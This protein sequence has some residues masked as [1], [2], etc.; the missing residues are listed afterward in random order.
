MKEIYISPDVEIIKFDSEDVI[1]TSVI[2]NGG[3][4]DEPKDSDISF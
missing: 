3:L 4:L 1:A 2:S